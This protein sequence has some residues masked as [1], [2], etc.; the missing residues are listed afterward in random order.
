LEISVD[1][2]RDEKAIDLS[3]CAQLGDA[4]SMEVA[5][6]KFKPVVAKLFPAINTYQP[7]QGNKTKLCKL[8]KNYTEYLRLSY[9][10]FMVRSS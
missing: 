5:L 3:W 7:P 6:G 2:W 4:T 1:W 10:P 8:G 9:Q